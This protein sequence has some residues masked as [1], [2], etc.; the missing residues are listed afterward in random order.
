[1]WFDNQA[2]EAAGFYVGTFPRSRILDVSRYTDTGQGVHGRPAGSV[3]TVELELDGTRF[4][5]LN[6][7]PRFKFN[8]SISFQVGCETQQQVDHF[9]NALSAGGDPAAQQCGWLKDRFGVS[10]QIVPTIL[11][12]L[13]GDRDV[14]KS[15]RA[16]EAMLSMKKFDIAA[17]VRAHAG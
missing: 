17:L 6:G 14:A 10:W 13:L 8:E 4:T 2:E 16:M 3:M 11:T 15:K 9:W 1:L 7:G 12:R 5:A